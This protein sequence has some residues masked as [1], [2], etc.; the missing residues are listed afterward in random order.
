MRL[1]IGAN[2]TIVKKIQNNLNGFKKISHKNI[3]SYKSKDYE[4]II[5][6]SWSKSSLE[7]N[8]KILENIDI[9]KVIFISTTAVMS[10]KKRKQ[11]NK[12]PNWKKEIE[13]YVLKN[14][15]KVLRIGIFDKENAKGLYGYYPYTSSKRLSDY[16]NNIEN[17]NAGIINCF[18]IKKGELSNLKSYY[19]KFLNFVA[20]CFP[21]L[22]IFQAPIEALVKITGI[23]SYGYT[24]DSNFFFSNK[25]LIGNGCLGSEYSKKYTVDRI[26]TSHKKDIK[27][28]KNGF[29][30]TLVGYY[31]NGLAKFWHGVSIERNDGF[32]QKKVP[33]FVDRAFTLKRKINFHI[34]KINFGENFCELEGINNLN[35]IKTFYAE[36]IVLGAGPI[37]NTSLLNQFEDSKI[38]FDDHELLFIGTI[39]LEQAVKEEYVKKLGPF[40][41]PGKVALGSNSGI[42]FLIDPRP[43]NKIKFTENIY[44]DSS[45]NIIKKLILKFS[46][47]SLNEAFF[48]KFG[49]ALKTY[50]ISLNIQM[51]AED[52]IEF[53]G[54]ELKRDRINNNKIENIK[55]FFSKKIKSFIPEDSHS[56]DGQHI[57]G[58]RQLVSNKKIIK[59]IS[60]GKLEILG[61]P[62]DIRLTE[63]HHTEILKSKI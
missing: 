30:D 47:S 11:W 18:D 45:L 5:I 3:K 29:K 6:F 33:I 44:A 50:R 23:K 42:R 12:Y 61:S 63:L 53:V 22:S 15:G 38:T 20:C 31:K 57:I 39:S 8:F 1:L 4:K 59:L 54:N 28:N 41:F 10:L 43:Y 37:E 14:N 40:I 27:L 55:I 34:T 9:T 35:E 13:D 62:C 21:S 25:V 48:N 19:A 2:S 7:E 24:N 52:C 60:S 56:F 32:L 16:L 49:I 58:G 26:F 36:K 17:I 46:F 51:V